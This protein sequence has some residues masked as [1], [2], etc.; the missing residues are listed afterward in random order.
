MNIEDLVGATA[1]LTLGFSCCDSC[2]RPPFFFLPDDPPEEVLSRS[3]RRKFYVVK[4]GVVGSE[5][6][7]T[8]CLPRP[9]TERA[10]FGQNTVTDSTIIPQHPFVPLALLHLIGQYRPLS[11]P[12]HVYW[13]ASKQD[14]LREVPVLMLPVHRED[15]EAELRASAA[16]TL[17]V[18]R[19]LQAIESDDEGGGT[20]FYHVFG[21]L[22][23]STSRDTAVDEL[24]QSQATGLLVGKSLA[25]VEE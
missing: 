17:L 15:A 24:V 8:D 22:R 20:T 21:S 6:I 7:Y 25:L 16:M 13:F 9:P 5:G 1:A 4:R 23:V 19:S 11:H 18:G 3:A 2:C 10:Q 14:Y 12:V